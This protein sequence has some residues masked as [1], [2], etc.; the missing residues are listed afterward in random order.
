MCFIAC[1]LNECYTLISAQPM[2]ENLTEFEALLSQYHA[3]HQELF[4][5]GFMSVGLGTE[6]TL[7]GILDRNFNQEIIYWLK[8]NDI[9]LEQFNH[10]LAL[11]SLE[12]F[13]TLFN[14]TNGN[15]H[16]A[17]VYPTYMELITNAFSERCSPT[18]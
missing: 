9:T 12:V 16:F 15:S 4:G 18:S 13:L 10:Y 11:L 5:E 1:W 6:V 17:Q 8:V 2:Q 3:A 7:A 14:F